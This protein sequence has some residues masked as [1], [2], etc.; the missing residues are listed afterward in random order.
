MFLESSSHNGLSF[1]L[2]DVLALMQRPSVSKS[3][4]LEVI[5]VWDKLL[6]SIWLDKHPVCILQKPKC[7]TL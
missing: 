6:N 2:P 7:R 4:V 1:V 5:G 3:P